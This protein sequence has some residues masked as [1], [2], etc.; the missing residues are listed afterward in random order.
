[1]KPFV[2]VAL[3]NYGDVP[4]TLDVETDDQIQVRALRTDGLAAQPDGPATSLDKGKNPITVPAGMI[5]GFSSR[6]V[7]KVTNPTMVNVSVVSANGKDPWPKPP[8]LAPSG[9]QAVVDYTD[10][11]AKFLL[12]DGVGAGHKPTLT[13]LVPA[14]PA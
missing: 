4:V 11:F 12:T 9:F 1:M 10:R 8:P 14:G 3:V 7:V 13:I 5:V 6:A 2:R